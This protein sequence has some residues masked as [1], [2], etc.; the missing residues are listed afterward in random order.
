MIV[1]DGIDSY[2]AATKLVISKLFSTEIQCQI[3][4]TG[5]GNAIIFKLKNS[6]VMAMIKDVVLEMFPGVRPLSVCNT[7]QNYLRRSSDR[8]GGLTRKRKREMESE[9]FS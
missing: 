7:L 5:S 8:K 3:T 6:R 2:Q 9:F 4:F 1:G